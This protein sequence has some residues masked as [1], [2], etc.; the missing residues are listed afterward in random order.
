MT[1]YFVGRPVDVSGG[2]DDG[3]IWGIPHDGSAPAWYWMMQLDSA[4]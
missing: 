4:A 2:S 1:F 3:W